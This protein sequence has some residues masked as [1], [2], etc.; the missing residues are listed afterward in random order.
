MNSKLKKFDIFKNLKLYLND[1]K[2]NF[3]Y[4]INIKKI[5]TNKIIIISNIKLFSLSSI[6][7]YNIIK[8]INLIINLLKIVKSNKINYFNN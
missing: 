2:I 1:D 4:K 3:N 5:G 8:L 6:L 7:K